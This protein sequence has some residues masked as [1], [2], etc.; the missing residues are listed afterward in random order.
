M[1]LLLA[2]RQVPA[3]AAGNA[4]AL[5]EAFAVRV[6]QHGAG[7]PGL[8]AAAI[9]PPGAGLVAGDAIQQANGARVASCPELERVAA[10]AM[11]NGLALLLAVER[12]GA[13]TAVAIVAQPAR[14]PAA[15]G[16][17]LPTA[18]ALPAS[19]APVADAR[20][21]IAQDGQRPG[22]SREHGT[23]AVPPSTGGLDL[24]PPP[25]SS[26]QLRACAA[27]ARQ[28]VEL[29]DQLAR[30]SVPMT[31]YDRRLHDTTNALLNLE[32][33][34]DEPAASMRVFLADILG[35]YRTASD[36]RHFADDFQRQ[37]EVDVRGTGTDRMPYF[38]DSAVTEWVAT[39]PFLHA[40]LLESPR[41]GRWFESA[42]IWNPD[43]AV[44]LLWEQARH[45]LARLAEWSTTA[46]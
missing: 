29:L 27:Q 5:P 1:T 42:G 36:I 7:A 16:T 45:R 2:S 39:Y 44:E 35:Y 34:S 28:D 40:S 15:K 4:C 12:K 21:T 24:P 43:R 26:S 32:C 25:A 46:R 13:L 33:G 3:A 22:A 14:E 38:A 18:S 11:A 10:D 37:R 23:G 41:P 9:Q 6:E 31:A 17:E 19:P 20:V 8:F 30:L